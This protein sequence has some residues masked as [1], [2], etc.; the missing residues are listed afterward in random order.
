[1]SKEVA[2]HG[3]SLGFILQDLLSQILVGNHFFLTCNFGSPAFDVFENDAQAKL[4]SLPSFRFSWQISSL[5]L[6]VVLFVSVFY[7]DQ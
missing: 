6:T 4:L 2:V 5:F 1:M 7:L 3:V